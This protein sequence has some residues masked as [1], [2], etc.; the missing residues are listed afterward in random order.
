MNSLTKSFRPLH[1]SSKG[2]CS[3]LQQVVV[4][5]EEQTQWIQGLDDGE[6]VIESIV[7]NHTRNQEEDEEVCY[8]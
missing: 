2:G 4:E 8:L 6:V 3:L 5:G 7:E 1:S